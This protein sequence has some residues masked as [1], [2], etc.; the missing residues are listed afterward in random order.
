MTARLVEL[1]RRRGQDP[2]ALCREAEVPRNLVTEPSARV[3]YTD[4]DRLLERVAARVGAARLALE[5][6]AIYDDDT[7]DS[8]GLVLVTS[9]TYGEG[10][11]RALAYQRLWGDGER[12][13]WREDAGGLVI[14]FR[15]PGP[16]ELAAAVCTELAFLEIVGGA[17]L[18]VGSD[19]RAARVRLRHVPGD[20]SALAAALGVAVEART[21]ESELWL[22]ASACNAA[23]RIP[24]AQ[25][26]A[27]AERHATRSLGELP[28]HASMRRRV[29][30]LFENHAAEAFTLRLADVAARL[31]TS[32]RSLQRALRAEGSSL[33]AIVDD[34]R[35]ERVALHLAQGSSV[36]E[37][38]FLV[39][40]ADPGAL[41]RARARWDR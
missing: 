3:P 16:S 11:R 8:A 31:R 6:A 15:H 22:D 28:D 40:F 32:P 10:L 19:V 37:T 21:P 12:F 17:R 26:R 7:Y 36:K 33:D 38:A 27:F 23:I 39:G 25:M 29:R 30:A 9:P 14:R 20:A 18:L 5:L 24:E 35:R 1:A 13:S 34:V 4:A 41:A 2:E